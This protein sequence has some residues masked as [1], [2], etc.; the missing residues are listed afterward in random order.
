MKCGL[1]G[2][3]GAISETRWW[4]VLKRWERDDGLE[5]SVLVAMAAVSVKTREKG[6]LRRC[7][8][9]VVVGWFLGSGV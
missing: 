2:T 5:E 4:A 9:G 6:I 1:H 3:T 7:I 8:A